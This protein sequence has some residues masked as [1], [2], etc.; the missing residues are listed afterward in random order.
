MLFMLT[1]P[2]VCDESQIEKMGLDTNVSLEVQ[3]VSRDETIRCTG[4]PRLHWFFGFALINGERYA[5]DLCT[6]RISPVPGAEP[7]SCIAPLRE[8]VERLSPNENGTFQMCTKKFGS[9]RQ[10]VQEVALEAPGEY[11]TNGIV[12]GADVH[13]LARKL[14]MKHLEEANQHQHLEEDSHWRSGWRDCEKYR[15]D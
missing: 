11:T 13:R 10:V 15:A 7:L 6:S 1:K 2:G 9:H 14:A 12:R 3:L 8:H 5:V 4:N